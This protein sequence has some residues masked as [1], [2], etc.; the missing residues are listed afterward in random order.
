MPQSISCNTECATCQR[1]R[2]R[3]YVYRFVGR[4]LKPL[5][6]HTNESSHGEIRRFELGKERK[7]STF[8]KSLA[9]DFSPRVGIEDGVPFL[10]REFDLLLLV[11]AH[12]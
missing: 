3:A 5:E 7:L 9:T 6:R 8:C 2:Q 10:R 12:T 1:K 11:C 4:E